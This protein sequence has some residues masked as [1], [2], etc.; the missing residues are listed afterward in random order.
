MSNISAQD[1]YTEKRSVCVSMS[2]ITILGLL[3]AMSKGL[4]KQ[5]TSLRTGLEEQKDV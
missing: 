1:R 3:Y 4:E 2:R 5:L